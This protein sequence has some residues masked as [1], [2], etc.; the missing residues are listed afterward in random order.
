MPVCL[1][2]V[3]GNID[4]QLWLPRAVRRLLDFVRVE[5][6]SPFF[7]TPPI[8]RPEQPDYRNGVLRCRTELQPRLLKFEV[9]RTIEAE[10]GRQRGGD[11]YAART[12]DLDLL[13]WGGVTMDE[14]GLRLPDPDLADRPFLAAAVLT[15]DPEYFQPVG[16][17]LRNRLDPAVREAYPV[18]IPLTKTIEE[19]IAHEYRARQ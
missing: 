4:P 18:D 15:L 2:S 14:P 11:P 8:G 12:V 10:N 13:D 17:L 3:A 16:G 6:A 1:I 7:V 19:M 9:L 5:A